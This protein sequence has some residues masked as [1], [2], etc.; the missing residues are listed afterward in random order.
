MLTRTELERTGDEG[1]KG[2]LQAEVGQLAGRLRKL[3]SFSS[4]SRT[5]G[6]QITGAKFILGH[7][8][9]MLCIITILIGQ[10]WRKL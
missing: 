7:V 4:T 8:F 1:E 9:N 2:R 5:K 6:K 10:I 3:I